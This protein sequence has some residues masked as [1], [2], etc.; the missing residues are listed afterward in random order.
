GHQGFATALKLDIRTHIGHPHLSNLAD[1]TL[2]FY[3][4]NVKQ[5]MNLRVILVLFE[6]VSGLPINWRKSSFF[7]NN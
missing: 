4:A 7:P 6:R 2:I 3:A 1:D 5:L